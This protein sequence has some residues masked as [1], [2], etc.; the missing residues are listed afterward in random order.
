[1]DANDGASSGPLRFGLIVIGDE[2]LSGGRL[3]RHL[4][5]FKGRLRERGH[6]LLWHWLLP[7]D[8]QVL[9]DHL[10]FSIGRPDP[11]FICGGIGA[12]PD[13]R[14][15]ASAAAAA[16]AVIARHPEAAALIEARFGADAYPHRILMADLPEGCA[17]IPN[18]VNRIPGFSLGEHH[19]LPGFPEMAWP[20]ADWVLVQRYPAVAEPVRE[21]AIRIDGVPESRLVPLM[22]RLTLAF[23]AHKLFSLPRLGEEPHVLLGLRGRA[24]LDAAFAQLCD[25]VAREGLDYRL[26]RMRPDE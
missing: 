21:L 6:E 26:V 25:E 24:G 11:V 13:D 1:M 19:F 12:T 4:P 5:H 8:E 22:Q 16:G 3:D 15:R 14:T 10:R 7:D 2:L 23:P 18:V 20:M 17:L 9:T